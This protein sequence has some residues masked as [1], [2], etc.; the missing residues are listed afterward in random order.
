MINYWINTVSLDHVLLG[1][2]GGFTQANHG[3]ATNLKRLT[4]GDLIV[5]YSGRTSLNQGVPL[6]KFTAM[7][8]VIDEEPYQVTMGPDFHPWRRRVEPLSS[9]EVSIH[10]LIDQLT[11]IGDKQRW[12]FPFRRGLF[13]IPM[14]DFALI[15]QTM[16]VDQSVF[17][18][19]LS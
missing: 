13:P 8:R 11:F 3:R 1:M 7:A 10:P 14:Q 9:I 6:Q 15:A 19:V 4:K 2:E 5:F 12:G 16:D 17:A 18:G